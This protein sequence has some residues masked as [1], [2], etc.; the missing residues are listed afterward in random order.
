M[1][2]NYFNHFPAI[3]ICQNTLVDPLVSGSDE[4]PLKSE[5]IIVRYHDQHL[6]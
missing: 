5:V 4:T 6:Y 1:E 2:M 3:S